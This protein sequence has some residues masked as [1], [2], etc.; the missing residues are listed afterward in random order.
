MAVLS[1]YM[2]QDT[3]YHN[4]FALHKKKC[5]LHINFIKT[6]KLVTNKA[7]AAL[8]FFRS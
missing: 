3:L 6:L 1:H 4:H 2:N 8:F 7:P 5:C